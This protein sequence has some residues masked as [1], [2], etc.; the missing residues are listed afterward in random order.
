MKV[1][2]LAFGIVRDMVGGGMFVVDMPNICTVG[3]LTERLMVLYPALMRLS[4]FTVAVNGEYALSA[5]VI[6][7]GDEVALIPP[8]SG[9]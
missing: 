3:E 1:Y 5:T 8:V 9:G 2:I 7:E 6:A 4:T